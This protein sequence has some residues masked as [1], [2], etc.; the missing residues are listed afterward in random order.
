MKISAQ[1]L[2]VNPQHE[3]LACFD[4]SR[5][6]LNLFT[7]FERADRTYFIED[8]IAN[9]TDAIEH[10]LTRLSGIAVEADLEHLRV[11]CEPTGGYEQ[12]LL[13]TAERLGHHTALIS[14]EHVAGLKQGGVQRHG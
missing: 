4:V 12:K 9:S 1:P 6:V 5:K 8:E 2:H 14:S 3:L 13:R 10:I 7:R 11:L